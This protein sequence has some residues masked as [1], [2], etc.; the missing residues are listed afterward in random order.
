[1]HGGEKGIHHGPD[2]VRDGLPNRTCYKD[3]VCDGEHRFPPDVVREHPGDKAANEG[4]QRRRCRNEL[5]WLYLI[6][7]ATLRRGP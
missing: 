7:V 2:G 3:D 4:A 6:L 1:M 5:L